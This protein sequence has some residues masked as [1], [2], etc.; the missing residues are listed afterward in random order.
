ML[1]VTTTEGMLNGVHSHTTD[2]WPAVPLG[3]VLVVGATSLQDGL[4]NTTA[5]GNHT[6]NSSVGSGDHFLGA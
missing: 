5:S 1:M 6:D 4:V 2:T 3:L